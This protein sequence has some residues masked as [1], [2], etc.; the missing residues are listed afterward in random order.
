MPFH[1]G[2]CGIAMANNEDPNF[3]D[4]VRFV[5]WVN[6]LD[7]TYKIFLFSTLNAIF[8]YGALTI[9]QS[10][11]PD[12]IKQ[13]VV[14]TFIKALGNPQ[15]ISAWGIIQYV[16]AIIGIIQLGLSISAILKYRLKGIVISTFAFIG[17]FG[18]FYSS[19]YSWPQWV[20][21]ILLGLIFISI[22]IARVS[23]KL[24]FD[25]EGKVIYNGK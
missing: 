18:L 20:L 9:G 24:E 3:Q 15:L 11:D 16:L 8:L 10:V 14:D 13:L 4:A 2:N 25:K 23:S 7:D 17:W 5:N 12:A 6:E 22:I 21:W 19:K 1:K